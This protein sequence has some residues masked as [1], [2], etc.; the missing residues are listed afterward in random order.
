MV[1]QNSRLVAS[2][3]K[4][5]WLHKNDPKSTTKLTQKWSIFLLQNRQGPDCRRVSRPPH[6]KET[7]KK[8]GPRRDPKSAKIWTEKWSVFLLQNRHGPDW[9]RVSRPPNLKGKEKKMGPK[10]G[11][12]GRGAGP[13][14]RP[15][16]LWVAGSV[17]VCWLSW[18][19][20]RREGPGLRTRLLVGGLVKGGC[21]LSILWSLP[22]FRR[23]GAGPSARPPF[24]WVAGS[25]CGGG[26]LSVLWSWP[27]FR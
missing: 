14:A 15:P 18:P 4:K 27:Q 26:W 25:V 13:S 16:F 22:Q 9:R 1:A 6:L 10:K 11:W 20:F 12:Q 24:L 8:R 5:R 21:R 17:R 3:H 2:A 19:Q 7:E 23:D